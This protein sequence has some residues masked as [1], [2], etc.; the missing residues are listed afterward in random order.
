[1]QTINIFI[2]HD[3]KIL[4]TIRETYLGFQSATF[5]FIV[6]PSLDSQVFWT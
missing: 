3:Q 4:A 5:T 1:M 2:F 6:L